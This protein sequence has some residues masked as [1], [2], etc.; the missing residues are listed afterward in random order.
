MKR[1][2]RGG[3]YFNT[4]ADRV[5]IYERAGKNC[6]V[7][8]QLH[9]YTFAQI[10]Y[11]FLGSDFATGLWKKEVDPLF[12]DTYQFGFHQKSFFALGDY[13]LLE[14]IRFQIV[15][16]SCGFSPETLQ[17]V[18]KTWLRSGF[19]GYGTVILGMSQINKNGALLEIEVV[20]F[21]YQMFF[22]DRLFFFRISVFGTPIDQRINAVDVRHFSTSLPFYSGLP[23]ILTLLLPISGAQHV[24][25]LSASPE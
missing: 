24:P 23:P 12:V 19:E 16:K 25:V 6:T 15:M 5:E 14:F 4:E 2:R 3:H 17:A 13:N 21:I 8:N 9:C 20:Q 1:L 10:P 18:A 22:A 11:H 7:L